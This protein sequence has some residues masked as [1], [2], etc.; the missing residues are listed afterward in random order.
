MI[1]GPRLI[2]DVLG[3]DDLDFWDSSDSDA[4]EWSELR[5]VPISE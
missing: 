1:I 4:D 3:L 2:I 5:E